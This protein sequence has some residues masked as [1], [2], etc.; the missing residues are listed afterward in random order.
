MTNGAALD[1]KSI[2]QL[3]DDPPAGQ[4]P[5]V[6]G[7]LSLEEQLQP[8]GLDFSLFRVDRF[9]SSGRLGSAT[10]DR[11][12]PQSEPLPFG[13]DGWLFMEAGTY[14]VTFNEI[15]NIPLDLVALAVP[16]SSLLRS[17]VGLH[18]AIWDPGY[19]G[20]SQALVAVHNPA[21]YN[22]QQ[23]A[24][25]MQMIFFRLVEPVEHGYQGRY[26]GERP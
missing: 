8:S 18:T 13:S 12:L 11:S 10:G 7:L 22:L 5:L 21:G 3:I 19:S 9:T 6:E 20:Q 4:P 23:N 26:Q 24:R 1:R 2:R 15:V 17:G 14:R 16:R 25:L